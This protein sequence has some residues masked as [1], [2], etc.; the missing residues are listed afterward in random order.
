MTSRTQLHPRDTIVLT[1]SVMLPLVNVAAVGRHGREQAKQAVCVANVRQLAYAWLMY[2]DNNHG[3]LIG[4]DCGIGNNWVQHPESRDSLASKLVSIRK[5]AMYPYVGHAQ[6]YH[7]PSDVR[8][9]DPNQLAFRSYSIPRGG[10]GDDRIQVQHYA[11]LKNPS[12]SCIFLEES[13][14]RGYNIN[15]W[16][17]AFDPLAWVDPVAMWHGNK[18][19]LGFADAHAE[20]HP[21]VNESTINWCNASMYDPQNFRFVMTPPADEQEDI[22]YMA[23]HF[24]L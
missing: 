12:E 11:E 18:T 16:I 6:V 23:A 10:A 14:P 4:P 15:S 9:R 8:L 20:V 5:G 3:G 21:W 7:C 17:M 2:Q 24:P 19:V 13:D 1:L 22:A